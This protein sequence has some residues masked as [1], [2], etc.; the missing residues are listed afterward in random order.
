LV[1]VI[2]NLFRKESEKLVLIVNEVKIIDTSF[3]EVPKQHNNKDENHKSKNDEATK[4]FY[5]NSK[6]NKG[7]RCKFNTKKEYKPFLL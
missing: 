7:Y 3:V 2:F 5:E 4:S 1:E 6:K